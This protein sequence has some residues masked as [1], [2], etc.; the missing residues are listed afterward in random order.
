M[1]RHKKA[2]ASELMKAKPKEAVL[3]LDKLNVQTLKQVFY[4]Y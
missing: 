2:I 3:L 1:E 4:S